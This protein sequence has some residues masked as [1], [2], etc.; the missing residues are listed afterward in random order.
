MVQDV[1]S[2]KSKFLFLQLTP[3]QHAAEGSDST[4]RANRH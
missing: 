4:D 1:A 2:A 3:Q